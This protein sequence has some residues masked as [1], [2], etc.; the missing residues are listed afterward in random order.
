MNFCVE[1]RYN[2]SGDEECFRCIP[3]SLTRVMHYYL[4]LT[5]V[6]IPC[7]KYTKVVFMPTFSRPQRSFSMS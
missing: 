2:H 6:G 4:T 3:L 7:I 1:M 5:S